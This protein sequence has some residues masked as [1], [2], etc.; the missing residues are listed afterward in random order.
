MGI[1]IHGVTLA[2]HGLGLGTCL[3]ASLG[4]Y[5]DAV[6]GFLDIPADKKLVVGMSLG[7]PDPEA[8]LNTYRSTRA[9]VDAFTRWY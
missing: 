2:A 1:F 6:R 4:N 7:Y 9:E 5:P 3:Q 8:L